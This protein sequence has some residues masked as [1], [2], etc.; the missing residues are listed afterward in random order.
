MSKLQRAPL[1]VAL[2]LAL[3]AC[4]GGGGTKSNP[5][6][7]PEPARPA[8]SQPSQP[9]Q[10]ATP[11]QPDPLPGTDCSSAGSAQSCHYRY[12]GVQDNL[13]VPTGALAAHEAGLTGKGVK[14]GLLDGQHEV[15]YAPL[16]GRVAWYRDYTGKSEYDSYGHGAVVAAALAG[17]A[18]SGFGG[19]V[20]PEAELYWGVTCYNNW[21]TAD[22]ARDAIADMGSRGVRLYNWS[23]GTTATDEDNLRRQAEGYAQWLR[24]VIDVDGLLVAAAGNDSSPEPSTTSLMPR[25]MQE[26]NRHLLVVAAVDLDKSGKATGLADYSNACGSAASWCLV[27]PG[28]VAVPGVDGTQFKGRA[29][30]TSLAAPAVTGTTAMVWQAFPWMSASNVQQTILTTATDL[31]QP[32]VDAVYGWGLL[33]A[34][35]AV[36]GPGAFTD[37]FTA[38]VPSGSYAFANDIGG[39]GG[40]TKTGAGS[41]WLTGQNSYTGLTHVQ[42]GH[43]GMPRGTAGSVRVGNGAVFQGA[44]RIGGDFTA[45]PQAT[46]AIAIGEPLQVQGQANLA[47][48]LHLLAPA[49]GYPVGSS[50]RL[51]GYRSHTGAFSAVTYGSGFFYTA[52]LDYGSNSLDAR[53]ERTSA[54]STASALGAPQAVVDGA[55]MA[56]GLLDH[57][58]GL[59]PGGGNDALIDLVGKLA[60]VPT[61]A[62]AEASLASLAAEVHGTARAVAVQQAVAATQRLADR[63]ALLEP[64]AAGFW[65]SATA[66]AGAFE[67]P[68]FADADWHATGFTAG[69]DHAFGP[70]LAGAALN[71]GR[72]RAD[73]DAIGGGF[74]A[75]SAG[76]DLYARLATESG[77]LSASLG[78]ERASVDTHRTV[79]VGDQAMAVSGGHT[80]T[81][82]SARLEAGREVYAGVTPFVAAGWIRHRQGALHEA[83]GQ[84]LELRA[85][86]DASEVRYGELGLRLRLVRDRL[87]LHGLAAGRWLSGDTDAG[88]PAWFAEAPGVLVPVS[89]QQVPEHGARAAAGLDYARSAR[90]HWS[91]DVG[92]DHGAGHADD[93]Y[94][95]AGYRRAF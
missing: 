66:Q 87:S 75:D 86:A 49:P 84:G 14:V 59:Q 68:G 62:E 10:P 13:L 3:S 78:Y 52:Q 19:G 42:G 63:V 51:M 82:L 11:A 50:E 34:N 70:L 16:D 58:A 92:A 18:V 56:D 30:G 94:I 20:A 44:G 89:G 36:R 83:G 95:S 9:S 37:T 57:T 91:L 54:A 72:S 39:S 15:A 28:L 74:D 60:S 65:G 6:A 93:V 67:R 4:G 1:T 31:G 76:L 69:V 61:P 25:F 88:F 79:L 48:T 71:S 7:A 27:A 26:W 2:A 5:P 22:T 85:D 73:L 46:T 41:L 90:S 38:H 29:S 45:S 33:N 12:K 40:L 81:T 80:D 17:R 8:P 53:L 55:R 23:V 64:E 43:L 32:G 77:Y 35:K 24:G 47:G 21:C